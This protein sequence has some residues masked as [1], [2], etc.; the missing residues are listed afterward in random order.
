MQATAEMAQIKSL[1]T[2]LAIQKEPSETSNIVSFTSNELANLILSISTDIRS[3]KP[4]E[5]VLDNT[6]LLLGKSGIAERVLLFQIDTAISRAFLTNYW[7]SSYIPSF[8]PIGFEIDITDPPFT[9]FSLVQ[10]KSFQIENLSRFLS[11]PNYLFKNKY[12]A[13]CMKLKTQSMLVAI[14]TSD[15]VR[16]ALSLHF[17]TREAIWSNEIEKALQSI[18]DQLALA[19]EK[20]SEKKLKEN[21]ETSVIE[22]REQ[23]LCEKEELLRKFSSDVHDLPCS[24]IPKLKLA[25]KNNDLSECDQLVD[26]LHS[27]LRQLINEYIIPDI[28]LLGFIG[29]SYQFVNGFKKSFQGKV[30]IDLPEEEIALSGRSAKELFKVIKEWFCNIEKHSNAT[31]VYFCIKVLNRLYF[32][33]EITDNG[34]GF[35]VS[36]TKSYGYGILN[37]ERRLLEINSKYKIDSKIGKGSSLKIQC[38]LS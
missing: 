1:I 25:I 27:T 36:D 13:L 37:I 3:G 24:F 31:E 33:V 11:M 9:L 7:E 4:L 26:E 38:N 5:E 12:K 34:K 17:S 29:G 22:L 18:V 10:N 35:D 23:A 8:R 20:H 28:N 32:T 6:V 21:L 30:I 16:L 2:E 14:G 19:I 15:K